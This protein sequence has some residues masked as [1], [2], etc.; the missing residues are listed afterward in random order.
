MNGGGFSIGFAMAALTVFFALRSR[1][2]EK[3]ARRD[4]P[5]LAVELGLTFKPSPYKTAIGRL[6]GAFSGYRVIVDP[7]ETQTIRIALDA[8]LGLELRSKSERRPLKNGHRIFE[9]KRREVARALGA[10]QGT[11]AA[12]VRFEAAPSLG[13]VAR[14][15]GGRQVKSFLLSDSGMT[16]EF[17][18][19]RPPHLPGSVVK[20]TIE[21]FTR[22]AAELEAPK[23]IEPAAVET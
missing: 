20:D 23:S 14:F 21:L 16:I 4:F 19:G 5:S 11:D 15:L 6:V 12:I 22:F 18:F 17:D 2:N 1:Y 8:P 7:D 10:C 9:P 3:R 13:D